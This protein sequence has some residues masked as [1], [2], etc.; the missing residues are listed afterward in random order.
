MLNRRKC[1]NR[2]SS[3]GSLHHRSWAVHHSRYGGG[4]GRREWGVEGVRKPDPRIYE[5]ALERLEVSAD[6]AVFLDDIG[7]NLKPARAMGMATIRVV[8]PEQAL[9]ELEQVLGF[10]LA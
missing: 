5:I 6:R 7:G 3:W 10:A 1:G 4:S 9:A 8:S 2:H